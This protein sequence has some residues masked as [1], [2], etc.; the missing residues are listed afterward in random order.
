MDRERLDVVEPVCEGEPASLYKD[1]E[2]KEEVE[3][4]DQQPLR[5]DRRKGKYV[6]GDV[7]PRGLIS[8]R[9]LALLAASG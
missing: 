2:L 3:L 9:T 4:P 8:K 5:V 7:L 1:A 6:S